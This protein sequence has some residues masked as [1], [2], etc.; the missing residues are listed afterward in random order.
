MVRT[1]KDSNKLTFV[2]IK[3]LH[4]TTITD[5][6]FLVHYFLPM[7]KYLFIAGLIGAIPVIVVT[8]IRTAESIFEGDEP[9]KDHKV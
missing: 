5:V 7:F 9:A 8:A 2:L 6:Q 4:G 1:R 3:H